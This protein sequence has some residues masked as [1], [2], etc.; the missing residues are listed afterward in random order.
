MG[1]GTKVVS[2][3]IVVFVWRGQ[4]F[5]SDFDRGA[6]AV[7]HG[8]IDLVN[9]PACVEILQLPDKFQLYLTNPVRTEAA[10]RI[11]ARFHQHQPQPCAECKPIQYDE[12]WG[13][14]Y[15]AKKL[16][17]GTVAVRG[18]RTIDLANPDDFVWSWSDAALYW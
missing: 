7:L 3:P 11:V 6:D 16:P 12:G 1:E 2:K 10:L 9:P 5:I 14:W 8:A 18:G 15:S 4:P 13:H 17:T